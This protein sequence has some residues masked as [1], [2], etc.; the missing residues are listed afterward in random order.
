[1]G[2]GLVIPHSEKRMAR[3]EKMEVIVSVQASLGF[4][5]FRFSIT[6]ANGQSSAAVAT[7]D[8]ALYICTMLVLMCV[9]NKKCAEDQPAISSTETTFC[10]PLPAALAGCPSPL[11]LQ[12]CGARRI[13]DEIMD[14]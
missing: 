13:T 5:G 3:T 12:F 11:L 14:K 1:M 8:S 10:L 6:T 2:E 4:S 9:S 7:D